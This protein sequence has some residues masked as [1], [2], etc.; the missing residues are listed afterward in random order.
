V[1]AR[2]SGWSAWANRIAARR[3]LVLHPWGW[4]NRILTRPTIVVRTNVRPADWTVALTIQPGPTVTNRV[5]AVTHLSPTMSPAR[6]DLDRR[7]VTAAGH[8][9][10]TLV[11]TVERTRSLTLDR[12]VVGQHHQ[13]TVHAAHQES[14]LVTRLIA[15]RERR[16]AT[17][18]TPTAPAATQR[19]A[20]GAPPAPATPVLARR[21]L[22]A[23]LEPPTPLRAPTPSPHGVGDAMRAPAPALD[24]QSL[25]DQVIRTIDQRVV[26]ARERLGAR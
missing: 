9:R 23:Q 25:A 8:I 7:P 19:V 6:I 12:T 14:T 3:A 4:L 17:D 2:I 20:L 21:G 15:R 18:P 10:P 5:L 24:I 26:A 11:R 16:E 1:P 13:R 22:P